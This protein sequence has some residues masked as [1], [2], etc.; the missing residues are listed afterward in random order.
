MDKFISRSK[1]EKK[2]DFTNKWSSQKTPTNTAK[3][4]PSNKSAA[5]ASESGGSSYSRG[6]VAKPALNKTSEKRGV[7]IPMS[8]TIGGVPLIGTPH[9]HVEQDSPQISFS[10]SQKKVLDAIMSRRSV[11]FTGAAGTG[12]SFVVKIVQDVLQYLNLGDK[13]AFTAPTG[14]AACNIRGLTIHSWSGIGI[15][16]LP[17]EQIVAQVSR[18]EAARK[19]W[20]DA[21]ILVIDE[22]SML[23]ADMFDMISKV[24]SRVRADSRPF[25]GI[26][27]LLCGDFFQLPPVGKSRSTLSI[28]CLQHC[29]GYYIST[30]N[31]RAREGRVQ[32]LF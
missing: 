18:S 19:R 11:F 1:G 10:I 29:Y 30:L 9:A 20:R 24:G 22:I 27:V 2:R 17:L 3:Y 25:G 12:K 4:M 31:Y 5:S 23:S 7:L 21:D 32:V 28:L 15:G 26:Q 14:V 16:N 13:I 8:A 6:Y